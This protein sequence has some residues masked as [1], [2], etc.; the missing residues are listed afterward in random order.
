MTRSITRHDLNRAP[1]EDLWEESKSSRDTWSDRLD[2]EDASTIYFSLSTLY[3]S[4]LYSVEADPDAAQLDTWE[5]W[6]TAMQMHHAMFAMTTNPPGTELE[7][8]VNHRVRHPEATG[9]RYCTNASN[10]TTAFLLAVICRDQQRYRELCE[11]P[12]E[13]LREAGESEGTQYNEFTYRWISALQAFVLNRPGLGE[14]L[15]AA[16]ELSAPDRVDIGSP[17]LTEMIVFPPMNT[18]LRLVERDTEKFNDALAQGLELFRAYQTA[19]AKRARSIKGVVSLPL[20]AMACLAYDTAEQDP[21][22]RLEVESGYLPKHLVQRSW[23]GEF[24]V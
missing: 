16:M 21:D 8:M 6:V 17:E 11:V 4:A 14:E 12:V 1:E 19:D 18:L 22:F 2:T 9:P 23:Y 7:L 15:L 20:L 24:P 10:W 5:A 13:L 3:M